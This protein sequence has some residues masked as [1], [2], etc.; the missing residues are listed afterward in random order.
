MKIDTQRLQSEKVFLLVDCGDGDLLGNGTKHILRSYRSDKDAI[1][2]EVSTKTVEE[3]I[4]YS[5]NE[6]F[7]LFPIGATTTRTCLTGGDWS[8]MS[9]LSCLKGNISDHE[10]K[11]NSS[12]KWTS[13]HLFNDIDLH[14][15]PLV[16]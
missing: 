11:S 14:N 6:N 4:S 1:D 8:P 7:D 5:C 9:E 10:Q 15:E 3:E 2:S 13:S 16:I 12:I